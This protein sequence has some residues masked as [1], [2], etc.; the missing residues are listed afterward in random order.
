MFRNRYLVIFSIFFLL[1]FFS[2][3]DTPPA[4]DA[5]Q[6]AVYRDPHSYAR[7]WEARVKHLSLD[8]EVNFEEAVIKGTATL[9]IEKEENAKMLH[10]D[11]RNLVNKSINL[12]EDDNEKAYRREANVQIGRVDSILGEELL[13]PLD[14]NTRF[15][16]IRYQTKPGADA[17]QFLPK[18]QTTG[19]GPF[20]LTQSQ[21]INARTWLSIQDRPGLR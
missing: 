9:E 8:L 4:D 13:I 1:S 16:T 7:A 15:V 14:E 10:L 11:S 20:L 5:L 21:A 12:S 6:Q 18:E 19:T 3:E 2:C 17:L